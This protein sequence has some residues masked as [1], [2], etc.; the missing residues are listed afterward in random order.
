MNPQDPRFYYELALKSLFKERFL[1]YENETLQTDYFEVTPPETSWAKDLIVS[2]KRGDLHQ[3]SFGFYTIKDLWD[4]SDPNNVIRTLVEVQLFDTSIV[5]FPAYPKTSVKVR[6][7]GDIYKQYLDELQENKSGE[8][9]W[10]ERIA[11]RKK[12][13]ELMEKE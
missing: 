8:S 5:T 10:Q 3:N 7:A 9:K 4:N 12:K 2:V 11:A 1:I 6:S 13:L